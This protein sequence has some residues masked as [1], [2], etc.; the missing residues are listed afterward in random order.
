M[1][2][3]NFFPDF[4]RSTTNSLAIFT[5]FIFLFDN[6]KIDELPVPKYYESNLLNFTLFLV[7]WTSPNSVIPTR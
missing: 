1:F 7:I 6:N 2:F 3:N 5:A 4:V